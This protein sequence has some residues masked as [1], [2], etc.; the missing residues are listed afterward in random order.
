MGGEDST[1]K[2]VKL[3]TDSVASGSPMLGHS[4]C[5][6]APVLSRADEPRQSLH[7]STY[8]PKYNEDFI[9]VFLEDSRKATAL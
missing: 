7:A 5:C 9:R 8:Y 3:Y 2:P 4:S 1:S 6:V